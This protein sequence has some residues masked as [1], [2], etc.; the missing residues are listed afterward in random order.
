MEI[1]SQ[2]QKDKEEFRSI[3]ELE[4]LL[5]ESEKELNLLQEKIYN[6]PLLDKE[7]STNESLV[8]FELQLNKA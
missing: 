1:L 5:S 2:N 4:E 8:S 7:N 6:F 3:T